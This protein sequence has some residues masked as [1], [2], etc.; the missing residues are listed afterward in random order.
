MNNLRKKA[1]GVG[2]GAALVLSGAAGA[3]LFTGTAG[4][5][6]TPSTT[7]PSQSTEPDSAGPGHCD[8]SGHKNETP[9]SGAQAD[10][11]SAAAL[12]AVPGGKV[13][14][15]ETDGA[16][17]FEAHMTDAN[18]KR[19]TVHFDKDFNVTSTKEGGQHRGRFGIDAKPLSADDAA[20]VD[21]AAT[22]AV[23][24]GTVKRSFSDKNGGFIAV[25]ADANGQRTIVRLDKDF[26]VT[27]TEQAKDLVRRWRN[28]SHDSQTPGGTSPSTTAPAGS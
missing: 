14:K 25:V 13:L 26:K 9:L 20:K 11:A 23:P 5:Q 7:A 16:D 3:Y 18:G 17:G 24:G 28:R 2:A 6:S 8:G 19:V 27:G 10:Q 22:A 4:A 21:S 1:A 12:K 15:V